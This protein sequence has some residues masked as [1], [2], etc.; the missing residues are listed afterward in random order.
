VLFGVARDVYSPFDDIGYS[1][2]VG[3]LAELTVAARHLRMSFPEVRGPNPRPIASFWLDWKTGTASLDSLTDFQE[4]VWCFFREFWRARVCRQCMRF[5]IADKS[6]QSYCTTECST[7]AHQASAR[8]WW[9]EK[10]A[11]RRTQRKE[12]KR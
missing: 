9:R 1:A 7:Q 4:A 10:G 8:L 12:G 2:E 6:A 3:P 11:S 5:F